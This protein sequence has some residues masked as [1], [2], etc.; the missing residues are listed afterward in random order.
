MRFAICN[1]T[2]QDWP[3]DR[4]LA[5]T[6]ECGYT[7]WE[8]APFTIAP[9]VDA[10]SALQ[11]Q[12]MAKQ[13]ESSGVEVVGLHWLLAKTEGFH[14]TTRD[15]SIR[16]RTADYLSKLV[17]LCRDLGGDIMVLGSP[18]QR[19]FRLTCPM[20]RR[21]PTRHPSWKKFCRS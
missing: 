21:R 3:W 11:R 6:R 13:I 14:L 4:A 17:Q 7:G 20:N 16:A 19:N 5:L 1:E 15:E 10:I 12:T 8:I 9:T 18:L 2:F